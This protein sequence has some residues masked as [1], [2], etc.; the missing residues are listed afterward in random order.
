MTQSFRLQSAG[1]AALATLLAC[2]LFCL[3]LTGYLLSIRAVQPQVLWLAAL[4]TLAIAG[5]FAW[6]AIA[7]RGSS[8]AITDDQLRIGIPLYGRVI[9][10]DRIIAG[11]IQ[12]VSMATDAGYR[13]SWRSNGLAVP[14]YQLGWFRAQGA[15]KVLAAITGHEVLAFRTKDDYAVLLSVA[16]RAGLRQA[17]HAA[18]R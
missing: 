6:F 12:D 8:V 2:A 10:L 4:T 17:L 1:T 13:L 3:V 11:S 18:A 15:G 5:L 16:D 14:G 7:Q 9:K